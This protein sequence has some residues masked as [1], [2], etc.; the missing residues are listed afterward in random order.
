MKVFVRIAL[1]II[2]S[3]ATT[4]CFTML[5]VSQAQKAAREQGK[6]FGEEK[7]DM[8]LKT[9]QIIS[10]YAA[11]ATTGKGDVVCVIAKFNEYYDGMTVSGRFL[12]KGTYSYISS[13]GANR[14]VL[15]YM[16]EQDKD[17]LEKYV[18]D[19]LNKNPEVT[20]DTPSSVT[21]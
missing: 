15:V 18:E 10:G 2:L 6:H 3:M 7:A 14:T 1:F 4:S 19:F 11:L 16:L 8:V 13:N 17:E 21:I 20:V 9:F 5:A 12:K